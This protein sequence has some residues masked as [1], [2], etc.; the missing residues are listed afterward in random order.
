MLKV[1]KI[2][3]ALFLIGGASS[4]AVVTIKIATIAPEGSS[5]MNLIH[6][7]DR[8]IAKETGGELQMK[9]YA[10]GVAGDELDV[11]RKMRIGQI[12]AAGFT[13][14]GLGEVVPSFRVMESPRMF[15]T[16]DE[17]EAVFAKVEDRFKK[18]FE[19]KGYIFIGKSFI[20]FTYG[21]F[22]KKISSLAEFHKMKMWSWGNDPLAAAIYKELE[23]TPVN[24]AITD[25]LTSLQ[26][27][28]IDGFYF[29]TLGSIAL[30]W[31]SRV[32]Y[33]VDESISISLGGFLISKEVYNKI[34]ANHR[35]TFE[36][37]FRDYLSKIE[38]RTIAENKLA[39]DTLAKNNVQVLKIAPDLKQ[40]L[41]TRSERVWTNLVGKLYDQQLLTL[42]QTSLKNYR[43]N[44]THAGKDKVVGNPMGKSQS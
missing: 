23:V 11:L 39:F 8:K 33:I 4:Q 21:F 19:A 36:S 16:E 20:G 15:K 17:V 22:N 9:W 41:D 13:G 43:A 1:F 18:E 38:A 5:W 28:L 10:G 3:C 29:T 44:H 26:T 7:M 30:Q 6:E 31:F 37:I 24:L 2:L 40:F 14:R 34:P 32:K 27:G 42:V 35:A 12:H 25:V